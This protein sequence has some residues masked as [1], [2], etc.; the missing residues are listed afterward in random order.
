MEGQTMKTSHTPGPWSHVAVE[1]G[2]DGVKSG[3]G[4]ICRLAY[5]NPANAQLIAASPDLLDALW[6][7]ME[8]VSLLGG[9]E[10]D[11]GLAE[12]FIRANNHAKQAITKAIG[13][14]K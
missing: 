3:D 12:S 6:L 5:N 7:M 2:W 14:S 1:G 4:L 13:N 9:T 10:V 8:T 11:L